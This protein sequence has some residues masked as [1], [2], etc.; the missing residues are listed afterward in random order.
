M[1]NKEKYRTFYNLFLYKDWLKDQILKV[2]NKVQKDSKPYSTIINQI[3]H[4]LNEKVIECPSNKKILT[5]AYFFLKDQKQK[6]TLEH[7]LKNL[8]DVQAK[9]EEEFK[10]LFDILKDF[11]VFLETNTDGDRIGKI[12]NNENYVPDNEKK[13][14]VRE[15]TETNKK[16]SEKKQKE[17]K[18]LIVDELEREFLKKSKFE[19]EK[20][21]YP[22]VLKTVE[23]NDN[24]KP[25]SFELIDRKTANENPKFLINETKADEK[26][27][28]G[29]ETKEATENTFQES[30]IM[31]ANKNPNKLLE[32]ERKE[33]K[34]DYPVSK[35]NFENQELLNRILEESTN[36]IKDLKVQIFQKDNL[37]SSLRIDLHNAINK[38]P[39][40]KK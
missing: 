6:K 23:K 27:Y 7:F 29:E 32:I 26:K 19:E 5:K 2:H 15:N 13:G 11:D 22:Q 1:E 24:P 30:M 17:D 16:S 35:Q 8:D 37:I 20:N 38:K 21:E 34:D 18:K 4:Y 31:Y 25:E 33:S 10:N 28:E 9:F 3:A 40:E 14:E 36:E 12:E 39:M